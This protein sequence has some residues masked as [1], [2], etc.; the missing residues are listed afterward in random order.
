MRAPVDPVHKTHYLVETKLITYQCENC[1]GC[2]CHQF[3]ALKKPCLEN[4]VH[5]ATQSSQELQ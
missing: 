3:E 1:W 4:A 2:A 5:L